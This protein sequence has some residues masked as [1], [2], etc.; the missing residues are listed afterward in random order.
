MSQ[1]TVNKRPSVYG[2]PETQESRIL[3]FPSMLLRHPMYWRD[4]GVVIECDTSSQAFVY[5]RWI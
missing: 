4:S 3:W 5:S 1:I 2:G